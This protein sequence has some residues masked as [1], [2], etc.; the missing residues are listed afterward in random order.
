M[1]EPGN[2]VG[3]TSLLAFSRIRSCW[4][5]ACCL[6]VLCASTLQSNAQEQAGQKLQSQSEPTHYQ[7]GRYL[8]HL[9]TDQ[10]EQ[11]RVEFAFDLARTDGE[12][13]ITLLNGDERIAVDDVSIDGPQLVMGFA[14]Y[15]SVLEVKLVD[16]ESAGNEHDQVLAVGTWSKQRTAEQRA[17]MAA[18]V[19]TAR[20]LVGT[21][22]APEFPAGEAANRVNGPWSVAFEQSDGAV[23][24]FV[25]EQD[26]HASGTILTTTG[27]YRYLTGRFVPSV[28]YGQ[29][30]EGDTDQGVLELSTFDGAHAFAVRATLQADGTLDGLFVSGNWYAERFTAERDEDAQLPDAFTQTTM[31]DGVAL[32]GLSFLDLEGSPRRVG[33][34]LNTIGGQARVVIVFG[35]WCP[36]CSDASAELVRLQQLYGEDL[37]VVGL[38]FEITDDLSRSAAQIERYRARNGSTWPVL[39]AGV[40]DKAKATQSLRVLDRVRSYPTT[41]FL[42]EQNE[43]VAVHTGFAGPATGA[44]HQEQQ[45]RW[46]EIIEKLINE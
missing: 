15:D 5:V 25:V 9:Q 4:C 20:E 41:L 43:V 8:V 3:V 12:W 18:T 45:A 11:P 14:H 29:A 27:D 39:I 23:A 32:Q 33:D 31:V 21:R 46:Q 36:N 37:G 10:P 34:L 16:A 28:P 19:R 22:T 38:A 30:V 1:R 7:A 17:A 26:G 40:S 24:E 44:A 2:P 35:T 13:S 42:N 6:I